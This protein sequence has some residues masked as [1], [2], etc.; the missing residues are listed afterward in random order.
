VTYVTL[1]AVVAAFASAFV[2]GA[3]VANDAIAVAIALARTAELTTVFTDIRCLR[4]IFDVV[5]RLARPQY[6]SRGTVVTAP[7]SPFSE[8]HPITSTAVLPYR[9]T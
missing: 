4:S 1:K 7:L 9:G 3:P 2:S 6:G 5:P 8:I